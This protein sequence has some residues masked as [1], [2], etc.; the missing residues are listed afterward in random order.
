VGLRQFRSF[1][2]RLPHPSKRKARLPGAPISPLAH[3]DSLWR[4]EFPPRQ[5]NC[6]LVEDPGFAPRSLWN[7][8]IGK[9]RVIG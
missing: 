4:G 5:A 9:S 3:D 1:E 8:V 7:R 6:G 2:S